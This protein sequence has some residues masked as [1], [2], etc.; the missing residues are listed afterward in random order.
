M[1]IENKNN[2]VNTKILETLLNRFF[3]KSQKFCKKKKSSITSNINKLL[4]IIIN[5]L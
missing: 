3:E 4:V 2:E 1:L 5:K